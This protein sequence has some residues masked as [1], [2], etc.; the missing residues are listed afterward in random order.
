MIK[1]LFFVTVLFVSVFSAPLGAET[2]TQD[3]ALT[4]AYKVI[5]RQN[6]MIQDLQYE[7]ER[8]LAEIKSLNETINDIRSRVGGGG[9]Q[10]T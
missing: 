10:P 9:Y 3:P 5:E 7:R 4:E 6:Q 1:K 8:L 2:Q